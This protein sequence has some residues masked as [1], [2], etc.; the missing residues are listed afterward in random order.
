M[1]TAFLSRADV[2][3]H[4]QALHL[5]KELRDALTRRSKAAS[6]R[7]LRF[8][9]TAPWS[10]T[11]V[12]QATLIDLPA[13]MV[14]VRA[15][16]TKGARTVLQLHDAATGQLLAMMDAGHLMMLRASLMSA[17]AADVLARP[18]ARN[19]AVLGAGPAAS[20]ALKALRLV[21]S[22]DYVWL[23]EPNLVDNFELA[24]R[25][26]TTLSMAI[27][28]VDTA[29]EAVEDADIVVLTGKVS[30]EGVTF[31]PGVHVTVLSAETFPAAPLPQ[32]AFAAARRF[33]DA[34]EPVLEWGLPFH[35]ELGEVLGG[36]KPG[37]TSSDELTLFASI[38]PAALDLLA[39]WHVYEGARHDE[40]LTRID[41]EA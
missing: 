24:H 3:R 8:E 7:T 29:K 28:A 20:S 39:A 12:R 34:S 36:D 25:L 17:L 6:V 11:L 13:W 9:P 31:R 5:L 22:I 23:H 41:L 26:Q 14:T 4:L 1:L 18:D 16:T 21:R 10:S 38:G 30:L 33:C 32:P 27:S 35:A 15:E 40:G 2:S 19:V 37:R